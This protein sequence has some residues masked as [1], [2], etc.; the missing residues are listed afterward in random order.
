MRWVLVL[1]AR[2]MDF[3]FWAEVKE[4][5]ARS[6]GTMLVSSVCATVSTVVVGISDS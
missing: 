6:I 5:V 3:G 2:P 1:G 4:E